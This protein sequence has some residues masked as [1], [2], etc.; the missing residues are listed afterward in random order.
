MPVTPVRLQ[1][2]IVLL[3]IVLFLG[4]LWAWYLTQSVTILT[5]ALESTVNVIAGFLGLYSITLAAKPRDANHP[6][7]HGKV[8][9]ISAAVEGAL[10]GI[11]ALMIAYEAVAHFL[12][13]RTIYRLDAGILLIAVTGVANFALGRY[14]TAV[15]KKERS[16]TLEAAGQH[17]KSDAYSTA[18]IVAGLLLVW[19]TGWYWLD[20]AVALLFAIIIFV[21]GYRVVRRSLGGIM[22][23]ADESLLQEVVDVL[24]Q[25][26]RDQWIDMHNLR[27]IR[28]GAVLHVDAHITVPYYFEVRQAEVEVDTLEELIRNHFGS[29]VELFIHMDGCA[30]YQCRLCAMDDCPVRQEPL[31]S[32]LSWNLENVMADS[33][34]GKTIS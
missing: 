5:D 29:K 30:F 20:P 16:A 33:K 22:D 6:Y 27:V 9:Y 31:Q 23:E 11:A 2:Y 17:L 25:Q 10:I 21:T 19:G 13:P 15:G 3:S 14:A 34:H 7:G 4:K 32:R 28:Y 18:G 8:E 1:R 24:Q 12:H 26:R